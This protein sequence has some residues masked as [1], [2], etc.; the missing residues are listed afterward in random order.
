MTDFDRK[1]I[2]ITGGAS[3]IGRLMALKA[4]RLGST[5][6]V[7]DLDKAK[8]DDVLRDLRRCTARAAHGYVCDVSDQKA[9]AAVAAAVTEAVGDIDILVNNAGVVS[10]KPFLET[11]NEQIERTFR[12]NVLA[13]FWVTKAFLPGMMRRND[14]HI[15]NISSAGGLIG[16][17]RQTDYSASK[18]AVV[19][20]NE[21][22]RAEMHR[23]APGVRT[24][25]VCPFYI[26]TGMFAG[27][28]T[29]IPLLLPILHEDDVATRVIKAV[30]KNKEQLL[31]PP[32]VHLVS[33][34][35]VLPV[36]VFDL[37]ASVLGVH[38]SMDD[39]VGRAEQ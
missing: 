33:P 19:G 2:L 12:V 35:R 39:F 9:V 37:I 13:L 18:H 16:V 3:G 17:P 23:L 21:S 38:A 1:T 27:A 14:G 29:R 30:R 31:M 6:V 15:V 22:L 32:L 34:L 26:D 25:V 24:T 11:S 4:A 10:G 28:K 36:P 20:F 5:V 7:W 8:L